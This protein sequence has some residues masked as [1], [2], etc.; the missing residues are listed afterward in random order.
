MRCQTNKKLT[1]TQKVTA[2]RINTFCML[3]RIHHAHRG[4]VVYTSSSKEEVEK[5]RAE[6]EKEREK[7]RAAGE[8]RE[9]K[10][11]EA[12][13]LKAAADAERIKK[14]EEQLRWSKGQQ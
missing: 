9:K 2:A 8:E 6:A 5:V 1:M 14:L 4:C 10:Y 13:A 3:V 12:A 11:K 7:E